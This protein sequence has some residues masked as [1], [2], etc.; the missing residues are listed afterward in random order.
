MEILQE[1]NKLGGIGASDIGKLFTREGLKAKT[2]QSLALEK[3]EEL[4]NGYRKDLTTIAMQH[5][6]FNEEEAFYSVV[7]PIFSTAMY[8]SDVSIPI[9]DGVWVTPDVVDDIEGITMDIKCP[10]TIYTYYQNLNKLPDTYISQNQMQ[11]IGTKH[12]KGFIVLYLTANSI[13]SYGNKIE[14]DIPIEERHA[15]LP[16]V[17]DESYQKEI[18]TRI[19][20]FFPIRDLILKDL[21]NAIDISDKEYFNK[22]KEGKKITRFK[23]K[24][25]L[26]TWSGKIF[27]NEREGYLVIE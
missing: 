12:K 16:I 8:R 15:F 14:Y 3:A 24:S 18:L 6:L 27:K 4:I 2:A 10:Y 23:D 25:N 17:A 13:D 20:D 22:A 26:L 21:Q 19:D 9:K 5:G 1:I 7:Q 11:L